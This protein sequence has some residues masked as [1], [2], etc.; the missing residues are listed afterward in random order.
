MY[1]LESADKMLSSVSKCDLN[2]IAV[3]DMVLV[4]TGISK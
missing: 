4:C 1:L 2:F 3:P